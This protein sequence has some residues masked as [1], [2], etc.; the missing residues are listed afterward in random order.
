[1]NATHETLLPTSWGKLHQLK[2]GDGLLVDDIF[3]LEQAQLDILQ[4]TCNVYCRKHNL[5]LCMVGHSITST[6]CFKLAQYCDLIQFSLSKGNVRSISFVLDQFRFQK[7]EKN[8]FINR[9]LADKR[10]FGFWVLDVNARTFTCKGDMEK[11][12]E[13]VQK[14]LSVSIDD[15]LQTAEKHL[16]LFCTSDPRQGVALAE[17]ILKKIPLTSIDSNLNLLLRSKTSG[18]HITVNLLD[19]VNTILSPSERPTPEVQSFHKYLA[20][21]ILLARSMIRNK[22]MS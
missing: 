11:V 13:K 6:S 7:S 4:K 3:H 9:F 5:I 18:A 21:Y 8:Q 14:T 2:D 22:H 17:I 1:M 20:K 10:K 15:L 12:E 19:Y 16:T